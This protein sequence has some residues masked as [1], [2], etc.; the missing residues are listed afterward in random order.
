MLST[1]SKSNLRGTKARLSRRDC[2]APT[3]QRMEFCSK[4][5]VAVEKYTYSFPK[6]SKVSNSLSTSFNVN[7]PRHDACATKAVALMGVMREPTACLWAVRMLVR[8]AQERG[9][10]S[11][12]EHFGRDIQHTRH[13]RKAR[14][15]QFRWQR[16]WYQRTQL[17]PEAAHRAL[18]FCL[19]RRCST[20]HDASIRTRDRHWCPG[21]GRF[22]GELEAG[23]GY[24]I[25]SG[26]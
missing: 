6:P 21:P 5:F 11:S 9:R 1:G 10:P 16:W 26:L 22:D 2:L 13:L 20:G 24:G 17:L 19:R 14:V 18:E 12:W 3:T 25:G 4:I 23:H 8:R 15:P 7:V